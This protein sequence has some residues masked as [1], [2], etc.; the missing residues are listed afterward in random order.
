MYALGGLGPTIIAV[1]WIEAFLG[2]AFVGLRVY[3]RT[4][5]QAKGGCDDVFMV[6][7]AVCSYPVRLSLCSYS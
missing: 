5:L 6:A 1:M 4:A 2:C 7:S 3:C